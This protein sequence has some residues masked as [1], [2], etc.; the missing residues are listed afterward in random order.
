[1]LALGDNFYWRGVQSVDDPLWKSVWE[2]R[3]QQESLRTPWYAIL[4]NHDHYGNPEAQ[5]DFAREDRDCKVF[6]HCPSRWILPRYWYSKLLSSSQRSFS[7]LFVFLDTVIIAEGSSADIAREKAS[8]GQLSN[9]D[10]K[11]WESWAEQ[12]RVM[13]KLQLQWLEHTLNSSKADW[14][15]VAG[16]YPIFSGGEHGNTPELQEVVKPLLERYKVDAYLCGHDHTLQHLRSDGIDYFVSGAGALQG[17]YTPLAESLFGTTEN[18]FMAH[19]IGPDRMD[20]SVISG[21]GRTLYRAFIRRRRKLH[22]KPKEGKME[23]EWDEGEKDLED[24]P[25]SVFRII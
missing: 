16:H 22:E 25:H 3:F 18:G 20:V 21:S 2:D 6:K 14:I 23:E 1:M 7:A 19:R 5:I 10:L 11:K 24:V 8:L 12:R 13:A 15:V 17:E 9:D 4:G